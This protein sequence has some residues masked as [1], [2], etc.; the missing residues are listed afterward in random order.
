[1]SDSNSV[2]TSRAYRSVMNRAI[3]RAEAAEAQL[4]AVTA[5]NELLRNC[6]TQAQ[7]NCE[8]AAAERD[9]LAAKCAAMET[10]L[11]DMLDATLTD[12]DGEYDTAIIDA[13]RCAA[14]AALARSQVRS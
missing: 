12:C 2:E 8:K 14:K 4:S 11:E 13:A 5:E 1:M 6:A 10:A 3:E 9:A 7:A